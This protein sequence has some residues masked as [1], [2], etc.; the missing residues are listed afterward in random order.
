MVWSY[1]HQDD[2]E[3]F[4]IYVPHLNFVETLLTNFLLHSFGVSDDVQNSCHQQ[5]HMYTRQ[6]QRRKEKIAC[7]C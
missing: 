6:S 3:N 7:L 5:T 2:R 4:W 1:C